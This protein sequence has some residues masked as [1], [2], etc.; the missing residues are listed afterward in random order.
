[1]KIIQYSIIATFITINGYA[2]TVNEK[3]GKLDIKIKIPNDYIRIDKSDT[4]FAQIMKA[5][6]PKTN[7]LFAGYASKS[8]LL[9][10][11]GGVPQSPYPYFMVQTMKAA[12]LNGVPKELM[13]KLL[14]N[15][16]T[17]GGSFI[18][19][20][21]S[22][23]AAEIRA[24]I[25]RAAEARAGG[26]VKLFKPIV[27]PAGVLSKSQNHVTTLAFGKFK[28]LSK[29]SNVNIDVVM[30]MSVIDVDGLPVFL[31]VY[32]KDQGDKQSVSKVA[33]L[34]KEVRGGISSALTKHNN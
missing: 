29:D 15:I 34:T 9:G 13:E 23:K 19:T 10:R 17:S 21:D 1:M 7:H 8:S 2:Q 27:I 31:F 32:A 30:T 20:I 14:L 6:V 22:V 18:K 5:G 26:E 16:E 33:A 28:A 24:R 11:T 12:A 3:Y 4:D 25:G